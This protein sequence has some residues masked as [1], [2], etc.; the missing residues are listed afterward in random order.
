MPWE[1]GLRD[2]YDG[3]VGA[4][5]NNSMHCNLY[6]SRVEHYRFQHTSI[7]TTNPRMATHL[8][9]KFTHSP[10]EG[11]TLSSVP[12]IV[13]HKPQDSQPPSSGRSV[14]ILRRVSHH[15]QDDQPITIVTIIVTVVTFKMPVWTKQKI[16]H[17]V[18]K[19]LVFK[20]RQLSGDNGVK[21]IFKW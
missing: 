9:R 5:Q 13:T 8:L 19:P 10:M 21:C 18:T 4:I 11:Q 17:S 20:L 12:L 6:F 3:S 16:D 7:P 2:I 15:P 14:T 1:V